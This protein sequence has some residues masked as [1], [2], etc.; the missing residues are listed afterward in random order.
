MSDPAHD[1]VDGRRR[2][3]L[4]AWAFAI[5]LAAVLAAVG[6]Q[7]TLTLNLSA[8]AIFGGFVGFF[9]GQR[10]GLRRLFS[11]LAMTIGL[12]TLTLMASPAPFPY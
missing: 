12:V 2:N 5:S 4:G 11:V 1:S 7:Q 10:R 3:A 8:V 9:E 6:D